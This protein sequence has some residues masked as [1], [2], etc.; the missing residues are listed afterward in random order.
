MLLMMVLWLLKCCQ[1]RENARAHAY[2]GWGNAWASD[3]ADTAVSNYCQAFLVVLSQLECQML[4]N[5]AAD[6]M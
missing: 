2:V 5:A 6:G 4:R 1:G 3:G